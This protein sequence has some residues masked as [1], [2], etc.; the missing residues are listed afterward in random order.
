MVLSTKRA[1]ETKLSA[2]IS[3]LRFLETPSDEAIMKLMGH[4]SLTRDPNAPAEPTSAHRRQVKDDPEVIAA[5]RLL[6]NSTVAI[7]DRYGSMAAAR[8]KAQE[9]PTI[10]TELD[11]NNRLKKD[12]DRLSKTKLIELFETSREEYFSILGA[13]C[14]RES[15]HGSGRACGSFCT[16]ALLQ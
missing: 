14:S 8:R 10:R 6:D 5:K 3:S 4:M 9:D 1:T 11:D 12:H 7:R 15:A 16:D 2:L 13:V